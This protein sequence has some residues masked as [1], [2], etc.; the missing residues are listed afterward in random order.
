MR[1]PET[2]PDAEMLALGA[3]TWLLG[4]SARAARLLDVTGLAPATL[5]ANAGEPATLAAV[6]GFLE[7][8]EP[9][10]LACAAALAVKPEAL[11]AARHKL[12]TA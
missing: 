4:D 5:R 12:E 8:H 7:A 1:A 3:L 10:L 6:L 2:N 9:D 11:V